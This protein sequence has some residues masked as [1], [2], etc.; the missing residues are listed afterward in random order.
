MG[1]SGVADEVCEALHAIVGT[2]IF[3]CSA[4]FACRQATCAVGRWYLSHSQVLCSSEPS[5]RRPGICR[6]G[7]AHGRRRPRRSAELRRGVGHLGGRRSRVGGWRSR[8]W[9]RRNCPGVGEAA[10]E[11]GGA[12]PESNSRHVRTPTMDVAPPVG[13]ASRSEF[14]SRFHCH[15]RCVCCVA[16]T[17]AVWRPLVSSLPDRAAGRWG[18]RE[19]PWASSAI[20]TRRATMHGGP[21]AHRRPRQVGGCDG[22]AAEASGQPSAIGV[23]G[24]R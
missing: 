17:A 13:P 2:A 20:R 11:V 3:Q 21:R 23:P 1:Q 19:G 9:G 24:R 16:A 12:T 7:A 8:I 5:G 15:S 18:S 10:Q 14:G 4:F 22:S 6:G